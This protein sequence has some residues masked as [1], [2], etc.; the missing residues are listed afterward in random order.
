MK[1]NV[2]GPVHRL[3]RKH[4][5]V[6]SA[7][8]GLQIWRKNHVNYEK[9]EIPPKQRKSNIQ[10]TCILFLPFDRC[11]MI[12]PCYLHSIYIFCIIYRLWR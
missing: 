9:F 1:L 10:P 8:L 2:V 3:G 12:L 4:I 6:N 7:I 5:F 11:N